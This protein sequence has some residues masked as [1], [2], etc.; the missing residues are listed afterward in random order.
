[1]A[2]PAMVY[3]KHAHTGAV[4]VAPPQLRYR[5]AAVWQLLVVT[6]CPLK[7]F[8]L[9]LLPTSA[10]NTEVIACRIWTIPF[11]P[12][13]S[14]VVSAHSLVVASLVLYWPLPPAQHRM[15]PLYKATAAPLEPAIPVQAVCSPPANR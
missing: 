4:T 1:M 14:L 5:S 12:D 9:E 10:Q 15:W 11:Q 7:P 13:E 8:Y 3:I 2:A 6:R